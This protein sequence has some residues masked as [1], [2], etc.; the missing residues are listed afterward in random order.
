MD[1]A[2]SLSSSTNQRTKRRL[3]DI[4]HGKDDQHQHLQQEGDDELTCTQELIRETSGG[5]HDTNHNHHGDHHDDNTNSNNGD[6]GGDDDLPTLGVARSRSLAM[7]G[8]LLSAEDELEDRL[9]H[10]I[11]DGEH[12]TTVNNDVAVVPS[13]TTSGSSS[14]GI[15]R[16]RSVFRRVVSAIGAA[17]LLSAVTG[18]LAPSLEKKSSD[19]DNTDTKRGT[20]TSATPTRSS[21]SKSINNE[22]KPLVSGGPPTILLGPV[23]GRV[24]S[25]EAR[26]LLELDCDHVLAVLLYTLPSIPPLSSPVLSSTEEIVKGMTFVKKIETRFDAHRARA[27]VLT[28][29]QSNTR[30]CVRFEGINHALPVDEFGGERMARFRTD[31][32]NVSPFSLT[33]PTFDHTNHLHTVRVTPSSTSTTLSSW[34]SST[35]SNTTTKNDG[36][37]EEWRVVALA[38]DDF[39]YAHRG[40]GSQWDLWTRLEREY[41][42]PELVDLIIHHGDQVITRV[43]H[44]HPA[45]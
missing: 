42:I 30:Y 23:V 20:T 27:I 7:L 18:H 19:D 21:S 1:D 6:G 25:Y 38:C 12:P 22:P 8:G 29:L 17:S 34:S 32:S 15:N 11:V 9:H 40:D 36:S 16:S 26:I 10:H 33:L 39:E 45:V 43:L 4:S 41:V 5:D 14:G 44:H 3:S 24:T 2:S 28:D 13:S 37:T 31:R 35:A